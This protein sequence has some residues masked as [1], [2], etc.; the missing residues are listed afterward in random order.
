[1]SEDLTPFPDDWARMAVLVAH[2]DDI[3]YGLA[4]A[5]ARWTGEGRDV[6]YLLATRGE[7]GIEGLPPQEA[8][9]LREAEQRRS[10]ARVGVEHVDF[11]GFPD[12]ELRNTPELREAVLRAVQEVAPDVVVV[13]YYGPAWGPGQPNQSD[14]MELGRAVAEALAL[15]GVPLYQQDLQ[16]ELVVDVEGH[17]EAAVAALAEHRVYLEVLDPA[18][19]VPEQA[20]TQVEGSCP[21][22]DVL[23][24]RRGVR[25]SRV[26]G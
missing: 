6:R 5:V 3:E 15:S 12:S 2:P 11:L 24:G 1:M 26:E 10:A 18:T 13:G 23:G 8:G 4:A 17:L 19:P 22:L 14:H 20:R 9:P 21:P 7:V 25:L 16:G